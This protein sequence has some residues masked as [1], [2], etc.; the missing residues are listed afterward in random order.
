[1]ITDE[2]L[3][4]TIYEENPEVDRPMQDDECLSKRSL[5]VF[6]SITIQDSIS[7]HQIYT[8]NFT[9]IGQSS[10]GWTYKNSPGPQS[11]AK[12]LMKK[13]FRN[14]YKK[15]RKAQCEAPSNENHTNRPA[16]PKKSFNKKLRLANRR[17]RSK[18]PKSGVNP[19][20]YNETHQE[21]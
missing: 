3:T 2:K 7:F 20:K 12:F 15:M 8:K 10:F 14:V 19:H 9:P 5:T 4:T 13:K 16:G 1:V 18:Y 11:N 17:I 6:D 21:T